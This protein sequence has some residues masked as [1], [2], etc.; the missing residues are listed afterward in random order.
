MFMQLR[1]WIELKHFETE[2]LSVP[3][4]LIPTM[5]YGVACPHISGRSVFHT[6]LYSQVIGFVGGTVKA[7]GLSSICN[8]VTWPEEGALLPAAA[9][10]FLQA[11]V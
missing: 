11:P 8:C 6:A 10:V 3:L 2:D 4:S 1:V 5:P 7:T 9:Q